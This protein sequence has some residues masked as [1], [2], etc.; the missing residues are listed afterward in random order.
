MTTLRVLM[1]GGAL[2]LASAPAQTAGQ[3][4]VFDAASVKPAAT[5]RGRYV[6]PSGGPGTPDP[7]RVRY[8]NQSLR[9][10]LMIAYGVSDFQIAGPAWLDSAAFDIDATLPPSA[11]REQFRLM[12][13]NL[14][15]ERFKL[16]IHR[17]TREVPG[18]TLVVAK[19]GPKFKEALEPAGPRDAGAEQPWNQKLDKAGYF[20]IP[21]RAG[22]YFQMTRPPGAR[23]TFRQVTMQELADSL[24]RQLKRPVVNA[25]GLPAKY[26]FVLDFSTEGLY[27]GRG[28]IP[29]SPG[30]DAEALPDVFS[31]LPSQLGLK[32]ES[33]KV[34]TEM[35][36]VDHIEKTP[37]EN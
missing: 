6:G 20:V 5:P 25:T 34:P 1:L 4:L 30:A 26:D 17:E 8:P 28:R 19:S 33:K 37:T 2:T 29:V 3:P 15:A 22:I 16:A 7:G 23:S 27:L 36:V 21:Q 9:D 14:L 11:T 10:L 24:Q 12:M 31:A 32:L 18:Y 35:I 13:Q